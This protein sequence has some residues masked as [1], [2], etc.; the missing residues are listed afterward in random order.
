MLLHLDEIPYLYTV[1]AGLF[2]WIL[3][4]GYIV[5]PSTFMSLRNSKTIKS[6]GSNSNTGKK[7]VDTMQNIPLLWL[8]AICCIIGVSGMGWL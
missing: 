8:A 5:F 7:V 4:A 6:A 1:L 2:T 3:L